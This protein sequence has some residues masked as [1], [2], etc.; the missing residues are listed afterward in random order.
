MKYLIA[1]AALIMLAGPASAQVCGSKPYTQ[2]VP[3]CQK[4]GRDSG[5]CQHYCKRSPAEKKIEA[6]KDRR[7]R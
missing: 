5:T 2:C 4:T 6:D 3:C 7:S 1:M